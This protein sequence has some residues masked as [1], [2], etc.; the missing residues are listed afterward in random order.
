M[1]RLMPAG[2]FRSRDGRPFDVPHWFI[3]AAIAAN[4][5]RRAAARRD[6]FVIDYEHQT[7]LADQNGQPAPAAGWFKTLEWCDEGLCAT[8]VRWTPRAQQM[9]ADHEYRYFSPVFRYDLVTGE[10]LELLHAALTN[11]AGLDGLTDLAALAALKFPHPPTLQETGTV[12]LAEIIQLLGLP[13]DT[14]EDKAKAALASLKTKA[15]QVDELQGRVTALSAKAAPV[16]PPDPALYVPV[17]AMNEMQNAFAALSSQ[18]NGR[19]VNDLVSQAMSDG[20]LLPAQEA[21]AKSLGTK[22]LAALKA[23]VEQ[24]QPIAALKGSQTNGQAPAGTNPHGLDDA[25]LAVC[26]AFG[27]DPAQVKKQMEG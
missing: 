12:T 19:E 6:D 11:H 7:L 14:N 20:K 15:G 1:L 8:D 4:V 22:D 5:I 13:A 26:K 23:F 9:I 24:A 10:V 21:W 3:D 27:N 25:T 17:A 16:E 18:V 2:P